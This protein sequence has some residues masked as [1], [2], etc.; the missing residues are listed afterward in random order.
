[1][2]RGRGTS[3]GRTSPA[4]RAPITQAS[5][6][7]IE[8]LRFDA[9]VKPISSFLHWIREGELDLDPEYQRGSVWPSDAKLS[10]VRS[11]LQ[12][13]PIGSV[14]L[15]MRDDDP[16][17]HVVDGKQRTE[18]IVGFLDG[19]VR[20]PASWITSEDIAGSPDADGMISYTD[21]TPSAQLHIKMTVTVSVYMTKLPSE[22]E[23]RELFERINWTGVP[24]DDALRPS[25]K[26]AS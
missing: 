8:R 11:M 10:L 3:S 25:A 16:I 14:F 13:V 15:N 7:P 22:E 4:A 1:M 2:A 20:F 23:E 18:A 12:G 21:L 9:Q 24:M 6:G 5:S 19:S 26:P 17:Y